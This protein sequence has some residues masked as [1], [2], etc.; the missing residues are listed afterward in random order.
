[1]TAAE[2]RRRVTAE[3]HLAGVAVE[4]LPSGVYRLSNAF[5]HLLTTDVQNLTESDLKTFRGGNQHRGRAKALPAV[6]AQ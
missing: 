3:L 1:M 2:W 6:S 5:G 4:K